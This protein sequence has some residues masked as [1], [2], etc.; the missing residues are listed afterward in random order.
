MS[1]GVQEA[2]PRLRLALGEEAVVE[3]A[4][5]APYTSFRLGGNAA[6]L[7]EADD[8]EALEVLGVVLREEDLSVLILGRGTN[9]LISDQGF[10]GVVVRLGKGFNWTSADGSRLMAGG[11]VPFPRL[12]NRA[13]RLALTGLEFAVAI[14]ATVGGA[15]RM[16]AG[17]HGRSVS[18]VVVSAG[19]VSLDGGARK[20]FS[21]A[22]MGME[23][24]RTALGPLDVV[25]SATFALRVGNSEDIA[26]TMNQYRKHRAE[27]QPAE[28]RNAGSMFKNPSD[29]SAGW[30]IEQ[31]GLKGARVGGA[32]VS[33]KHANFFLAHSGATAQDVFDLMGHV[34]ARVLE[35]S[36]TL[37]EPEIWPV[38]HFDHRGGLRLG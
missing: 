11:M 7:V 31:A 8:E 9:V 19:I 10:E 14:P 25:T 33:R 22:D 17:A 2:A 18:D 16:N 35:L 3:N 37:L 30:L 23:Y 24:R 34:Q 1:R 6:L 26:S 12:A 38:G 28:A 20:A 32:E 13:A 27:T 4:P 36:G 5:I 29:S 21:A 15:V